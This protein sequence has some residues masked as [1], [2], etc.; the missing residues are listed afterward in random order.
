MGPKHSL[1]PY[2]VI[3][4]NLLPELAIIRLNYVEHSTNTKLAFESAVSK[5]VSVA[6]AICGKLRGAVAGVRELCSEP[7]VCRQRILGGLFSTLYGT[8]IV[9]WSF[10]FLPIIQL[11][12]KYMATADDTHLVMI[13]VAI[14]VWTTYSDLCSKI[15]IVTVLFF[16]DFILILNCN[17]NVTSGFKASQLILSVNI[18]SYET[19]KDC[20]PQPAKHDSEQ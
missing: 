13:F 16:Q 8:V 20:F 2:V 9:H 6:K 11:R 19:T 15:F 12:G 4:Y 14:F 18:T 1:N 7:S 17:I 10:S 5:R 3:T